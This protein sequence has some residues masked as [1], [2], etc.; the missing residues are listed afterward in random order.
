MGFY[1]MITD[2]NLLTN[3]SDTQTLTF[4]GRKYTYRAFLAAYEKLIWF[5]YRKDFPNIVCPE[6][7]NFIKEDTCI[8]FFVMSVAWG[9][10]IR[11]CQMMLSTLVVRLFTD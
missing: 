1:A 3:F 10:A 6:T 4:L 5:S 9:C 2:E 8:F 11:S 7:N